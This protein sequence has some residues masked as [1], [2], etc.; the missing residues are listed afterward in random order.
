MRPIAALVLA[1]A[2]S[3]LA[4]AQRVEHGSPLL[5]F[6]YAVDMDEDGSRDFLFR[7]SARQAGHIG[8]TTFLVSVEGG[9]QVTRCV[10]FARRL[11]KGMKIGAYPLDECEWTERSAVIG[12]L[13]SITGEWRGPWQTEEEGYVGVRVP[14]GGDYRYGW[15]LVELR[16]L[17]SPSARSPFLTGFCLNTIPGEPAIAGECR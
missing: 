9:S 11:E 2:L 4:P 14:A 8:I 10:D 3:P 16:F 1:L 5:G 13:G 7:Y 15:I 17:G 12:R 6:T